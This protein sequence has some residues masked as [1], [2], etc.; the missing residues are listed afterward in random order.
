MDTADDSVDMSTSS[1]KTRSSSRRA[2]QCDGSLPGLFLVVNVEIESDAGQLKPFGVSRYL[3]GELQLDAPRNQDSVIKVEVWEP[4]DPTDLFGA[5]CAKAPVEETEIVQGAIL[6]FDVTLDSL[7]RLD[8]SV[9]AG[10]L[11]SAAM[12]RAVDK[13]HAWAKQSEFD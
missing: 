10:L 6:Y 4:V 7:G 2:S 9:C 12:Q 11:T 5:Y 8:S 1:R 3:S 13:Y